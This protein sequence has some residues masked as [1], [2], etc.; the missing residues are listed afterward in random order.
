DLAEA[1]ADEPCGCGR[2]APR[3]GN[4]EGRVQS[5]IQGSDGRYLPG[6]FFAHYFKD[7]AH[8]VRRYRVVQRQPGAI[9]LLLVPG[10][11]YSEA[12]REEVIAVLRRHLGEQ[13]AIDVTMVA[14]LAMVKS[15]K[16]IGSVSSLLV[17]M[18]SERAPVIV[19][20]QSGER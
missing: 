1:M 9:E 10:G 16:Q 6:T 17:D 4:I 12:V 13:T 11:R 2:G 15:G 18:Q 5:I 14:D 8:A 19:R 20:P 3:I 7:L